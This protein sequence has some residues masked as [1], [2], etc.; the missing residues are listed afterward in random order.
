MVQLWHLI[1]PC[2]SIIYLIITFIQD[3]LKNEKLQKIVFDCITL[4]YFLR[5]SENNDKQGGEKRRGIKPKEVQIELQFHRLTLQEDYWLRWI[6]VQRRKG[7]NWKKKRGEEEEEERV[8][9]GSVQEG[10]R[11]GLVW[12]WQMGLTQIQRGVVLNCEIPLSW[13][14]QRYLQCS[15]QWFNTYAAP[16]SSPPYYTHNACT[17]SHSYFIS[18]DRPA[19]SG[20]SWLNCRVENILVRKW[21][22]FTFLCR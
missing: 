21:E 14:K 11:W 3:T 20:L 17:H 16:P 19:C 6:K 7:C 18:C 10:W 13:D 2:A 15:C 22:W 9:E 8:W 1:T 5:N 4:R 12:G